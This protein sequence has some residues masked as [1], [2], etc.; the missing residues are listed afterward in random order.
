M[1][2]YVQPNNYKNNRDS[3]DLMVHLDSRGNTDSKDYKDTNRTCL[4]WNR[5]FIILTQSMHTV[6]KQYTMRKNEE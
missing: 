1:Q 5:I 2:Q 3:K 6:R 4:C